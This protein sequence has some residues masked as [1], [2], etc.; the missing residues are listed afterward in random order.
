MKK[1]LLIIA[2]LLFPCLIFSQNNNLKVSP[3]HSGTFSNNAI[4]YVVGK[5]YVLPPQNSDKQAKE[6][7]EKI[8]NIKVFPNPVTNIIT[9]ETLDKSEI[10]FIE[11]SDM[12]GKAIYSNRLENN[13]VDLSFL[14][15]G[16]YTLKLDNDNA[17][18]FKIIKD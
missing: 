15:Q 4:S 17:K 6:K 13:S 7:E 12:N 1:T 9:I 10:K 8:N 14:K 5:I 3:V 2:S 16:F 18:T 11:V